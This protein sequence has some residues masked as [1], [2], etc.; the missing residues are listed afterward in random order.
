MPITKT[1]DDIFKRR[2]TYK[3]NDN[4]YVFPSAS[5]KIISDPRRVIESISQLT[6]CND[7]P[8]SAIKFTCH[9]AR[10]T[11]ATIAELS[12]VGI[13]ILKRLMNHRTGQSSD[14][15]QGY[16]SLPVEELYEPACLI[17]SKILSESG[18]KNGDVSSIDSKIERAL[19]EIDDDLKEKIY[20]LIKRARIFK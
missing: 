16:I 8:M 3:V 18:L 1:L 5:G 9:D 4:K 6:I 7:N 12:G 13:Y 20:N 15:T 14:V 11:Y 19:N 10:R 17:E 2:L